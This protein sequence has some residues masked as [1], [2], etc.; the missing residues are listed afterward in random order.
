MI[1]VSRYEVWF[2]TG[3]QHLYGDEVL[4]RVADNSR[5]IAES[6]DDAE[7]MPVKV[8]AQPVLTTPD[9]IRQLLT[10]STILAIAGGLTGTLLAYLICTAILS[11]MSISLRHTQPSRI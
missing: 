9:A 8:I 2:V 7:T 10:E 4:G 3:S 1:D 6:L 11:K 5:R